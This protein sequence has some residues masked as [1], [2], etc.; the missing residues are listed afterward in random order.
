MVA[1]MDLDE[2]IRI[3]KNKPGSIEVLGDAYVRRARAADVVGRAHRTRDA[4]MRRTRDIDPADP[5]EAVRAKTTTQMG[6]DPEGEVGGE[7]IARLPG[8][9]TDY[10]I[11]AL[12]D[13]TDNCGLYRHGTANE[14]LDPGDT[15]GTRD[16]AA[17]QQRVQMM[18]QLDERRRSVSKTVL[19]GINAAQKAFW[20]NR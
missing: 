8:K 14:V 9:G 16:W 1:A 7:L 3:L 2:A 20:A 18:R 4:A 5:T 10:F 19:S 6:Q 15:R 12:P 11:S 17:V 13:D